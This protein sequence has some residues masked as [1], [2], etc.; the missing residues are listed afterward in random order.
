INLDGTKR[1]IDYAKSVESKSIV[2]LS[3]VAVYGYYGYVD[4]ME[5]AEKRPMDNPYSLSKLA[6]E[7]MVMSYCKEIKQNYVVIRPGNIYGEYDMTSSYDIYRL[8]SKGKMPVID[9]GRYKSCFV[10]VKNLVKGIYQASITPKAYNEDYNLTDGFGETLSEY[11]THSANAL[12]VKA[13]LPSV[14]AFLSKLTGRTVE[15]FYKLFR[16]KTMPMITM[17]S[18]LQNCVDYHFSIDK[19]RVNFG[20]NPE[21]S[22]EE[23]TK[24]TAI[25][26]N[27]MPKDLKVKR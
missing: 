11:L 8:L 26:F 25:W 9:K 20:Y 12:G 18:V 15:G 10:Y 16:I 13:K 19:A 21:V 6:A 27:T 23:G 1:V 4:L 17:F 14:P 2:Y 7:T 24:R 5:E 22:L 3:S